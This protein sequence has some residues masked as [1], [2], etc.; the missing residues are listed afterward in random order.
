MRT[1]YHWRC[2]CG[3]KSRGGDLFLQDAEQLAQEH[4]WR[5]GVGHPTPEVYAVEIEVPASWP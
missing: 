3:A 4:M 5:K 2:S 1:L